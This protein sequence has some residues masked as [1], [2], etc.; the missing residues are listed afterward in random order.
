MNFRDLLP[1]LCRDLLDL[2]LTL[3]QGSGGP[4]QGQEKIYSLNR[5]TR[6]KFQKIT[7]ISIAMRYDK[8][9]RYLLTIE[10]MELKSPSLVQVSFRY[11]DS[12]R[13]TYPS[14]RL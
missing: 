1:A 3:N 8:E 2:A 13:G 4:K 14:S 11:F 9:K 7:Q 6:Q 5:D 10:F 12:F